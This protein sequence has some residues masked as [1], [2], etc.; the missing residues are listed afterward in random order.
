MSDPESFENWLGQTVSVGSVVAYP[1]TSGRSCQLV[2]AVVVRFTLRTWEEAKDQHG[3]ALYRWDP[4]QGKRVF[5]RIP[6]ESEWAHYVGQPTSVRL[7][8]TG[9]T[10]RYGQHWTGWRDNQ[11][12]SREVTITANAT[13]LVVIER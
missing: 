12:P 10:S 4:E 7:Q 8:P 6:P 9:R 1:A 11:K 3:K 2:E 13:S 5:N